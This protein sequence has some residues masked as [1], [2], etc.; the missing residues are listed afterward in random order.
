MNATVIDP[1]QRATIQTLVDG[2][3]Q[4]LT[5]G[6]PDIRTRRLATDDDLSKAIVRDAELAKTDKKSNGF[7]LKV[8]AK[9]GYW[10]KSWN[11]P[12]SSKHGQVLPEYG[13]YEAEV[14]QVTVPKTMTETEDEIRVKFTGQ[15]EKLWKLLEIPLDA[16]FIPFPAT[17]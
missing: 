2:L 6:E 8:G 14:L 15:G 13:M 10:R 17:Q 11:L 3:T 12:I 4:I 1:S 7:R 16:H 5:P 9:Y